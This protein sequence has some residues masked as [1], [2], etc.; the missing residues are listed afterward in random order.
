MFQFSTVEE[1]LEDLK[2]GKII[3][4]TDDEERENEGDFICAAEYATTENVNFMAKYGKGLICM[5]MSEDL[6]SRLQLPQMVGKNTDNHETA[7]TVSIDYV[8]ATTG[9]S[10]KER[11]MTARRCVSEEA[12][13]EDF[14]RPGHMFPLLAKKN[15]VLEREGHTEATVDLMRLAGLKECGLCCE[16]MREDGTM[17]RS[18]ELK[19][20]AQQWDLKFI[21]IEALKDYRKKKEKLVEQVAATRLPT[22]YGEFRAYGYRNLLNGEHHVALVKGNIGD[23]ENILC[24]VHSECLTGDAFGSCRCDCGQQLATAMTQI[25]KEGRG[26][27]L[28]MRQE[29]RGIGLLNKLR[30]YALQ[31][32]GMDTLDANLALGFAGDER[33]Y[34]IGAQILQDLGVKTLRL[35][36]NNPD[37]VY[38]LS[39]FGMEIKERVPIQV[40]AT[41][42]DLFYLRTKQ[43]R[44][45]HILDYQEAE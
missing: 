8:E 13:P 34:Y 23:G 45:G 20:L 7:F 18:E 5:P 27:L 30:A 3:L 41:P 32:E 33:E 17:M 10:A 4:V 1:A 9:I 29:G 6:C 22:K 37:K 31:D 42:Y 40:E 14:R 16:I 21:T 12:K 35:L 28:Y 36:T 19:E 25:E 15:G 11:G 44:M 24:R 2:Q 38:Q 39:G 26:I 43:K